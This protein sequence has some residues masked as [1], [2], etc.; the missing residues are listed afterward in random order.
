[1]PQKDKE[2]M[3]VRFLQEE[4]SRQRSGK[5][6]KDAADVVNSELGGKRQQKGIRER[7]GLKNVGVEERNIG[8]HCV[9]CV[10]RGLIS[11]QE[12][13]ASMQPTPLLV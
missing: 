1:M 10:I 6:I 7:K 4:R 12:T 2:A 3:P 5:E 8:K 13:A 11:S 9:L